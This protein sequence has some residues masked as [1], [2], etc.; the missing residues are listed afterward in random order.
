MRNTF[1]NE[2]RPKELSILRWTKGW[3][4]IDGK[5]RVK[6]CDVTQSFKFWVQNFFILGNSSD[7]VVEWKVIYNYFSLWTM[8]WQMFWL[9][10]NH[11]NNNN[12]K[13]AILSKK[14][15]IAK[16]YQTITRFHKEWLYP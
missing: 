6:E 12:N 7:V 2:N 4:T 8:Q 16:N 9:M 15:I 5:L 10:V 1:H 11:D 14:T 13:I 3:F